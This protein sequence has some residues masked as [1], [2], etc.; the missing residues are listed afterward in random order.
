MHVLLLSAFYLNIRYLR[1]LGVEEVMCVVLEST[2][3]QNI[4][5]GRLKS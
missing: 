5:E 3:Q 1:V 2:G 4:D